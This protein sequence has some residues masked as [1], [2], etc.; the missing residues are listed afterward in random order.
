MNIF[1]KVRGV[2]S[3]GATIYLNLDL[4]H[5]GASVTLDYLSHGG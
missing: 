2:F 4:G 1:E 3:P 5:H